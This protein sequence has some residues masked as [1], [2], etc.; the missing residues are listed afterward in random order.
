MPPRSIIDRSLHILSQVI[1]EASN[2]KIWVTWNWEKTTILPAHRHKGRPSQVWTLIYSIR[3]SFVIT[4]RCQIGETC[5]HSIIIHS[6]KDLMSFSKTCQPMEALSHTK[7]KCTGETFA[8]K[9]NSTSESRWRSTRCGSMIKTGMR[10][11]KW[12]RTLLT[13]RRKVSKQNIN[14]CTQIMS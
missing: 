6:D 1:T 10:N 7:T 12:A 11:T 3:M 9:C 2:Y 13:R 5:A 14:Y 8:P 4:R